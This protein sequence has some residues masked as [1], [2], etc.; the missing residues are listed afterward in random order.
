MQHK[1]VDKLAE[2][3][4]LPSTQLLGL[5][6]RTIRKF[7]QCLNRI[8]ENFIETTMMKMETDNEKIQLNPINGQSLYDELESAAKV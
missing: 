7:V 6:N 5:F 1:T 8:A 2:E 4:D 3:L